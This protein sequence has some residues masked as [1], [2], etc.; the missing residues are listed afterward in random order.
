MKP[1]ILVALLAAALTGCESTEGLVADSPVT[2]QIQLTG[3]Y[4]PLSEVD[5]APVAVKQTPPSFPSKMRKAGIDGKAIVVLI[6]NEKGLPEQVQ[7]EQ[8]TH[9][10]FA[11]AAIDAI[12]QWQF[13]PATKGGQPVAVRLEIPMEFRR[14]NEL[15]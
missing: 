1:W 15:P 12:R 11:K 5:Q 3:T 4:Y 6:V 10:L 2:N 8:A 14:D 9:E 7:V 13:K